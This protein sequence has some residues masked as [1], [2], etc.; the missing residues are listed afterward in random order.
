MKK[1]MHIAIG[2]ALLF[3]AAAAAAEELELSANK[4][5]WLDELDVKLS[6]C[7]WQTTLKGK[8]VAGNPLRLRGKT[9]ARGIGTHTPGIFRIDLD[10]HGVR[11][12]ATVGVDDE[13]GNGGTVEFRVSGDGKVLWSSGVLRGGKEIKTCDVAL[14]GVKTL[15]LVVDPT[16]DGYGNDHSDWVDAKIEYVGA[17]PPA[18]KKTANPFNHRWPPAD[19]VFNKA[20]LP[21]P[22]DRDEADAV[23]RRVAALVDHLKNTL[24]CSNLDA[25]EARLAELKAAA[26]KTELSDA[27]GRTKLLEQAC[28]LRREV[29][30]SNP[31]LDFDQILFIKRHFCPDAE[32]TGNHMCDQMF[33]FNA[34]RGGG[35]FV[36]E[37]PFSDKPTVRN[38]LEKSVCENAR[39][40]GKQLTSDGG[41]LAPELRFDAREILFAWT[42]IA[43]K[44]ADRKRYRTWDEHNTWK[45]FRV[46]VDGSALTQLTDGPWDDF[47]PCYLPNGRIVFIS[48]R[49]G[50]Y[51]RCHGRPVPSFTLHS[52]NRD[53]SDIVCLSP[54]ETNE[55]QP[56]IDHNGMIIYTRWDYVDRGFSQAH[57]PWTT[58]PDGRDPR[59]IHGNYATNMSSRP[60]FEISIRAVPN[61]R[62]YMATAACHHGQAYGS[63]LLIDPSVPDDDKMGPVKR[64]TPDQLFPEAEIGTH[65]DPACYAAPYPLSEYFFLCVYDAESRSNAG[66]RN[67]YGIYLVDAFGNKELLYRDPEISCL[68]PIPLKAQPVP[69]VIPNQTA[70]GQPLAEGATAAPPDPKSVPDFGLVGLI[71]VYDSLYAM[72]KDAKITN[73]RVMQL[74]PKTT[75]YAN[76]PQIGFGDQKSARM[77]LGTVPV[78]EDG[79]AYFKLPVGRPVYFQALDADGLAVQSMRSATYIHPGEKL[80]CRGCHEPRV[81]TSSTAQKQPKAFQ[82]PPSEIVPDV[83]GS[84]PFSYPI[85][86]QPVLDK[87]CVGCHEKSRAEG[88]KSPDLSRGVNNKKNWYTSYVS[89][90]SY[91]F[92]WDNAVFDGVPRTTPGKFGAHASKLYQMLAKGHH[93]LK[94]SPE[95]MHRLTL[96]LDSNSDFYG[97]YENLTEQLE[98]KVVWTKLE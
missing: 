36:L 84:R 50:G 49:R 55:W 12:E 29:A 79:S 57:H 38:V 10:K 34:I 31:L 4:V 60:Q 62:K 40:Q 52:M 53:G 26:G 69:P 8:S 88:K 90:R 51:G 94:L 15:D 70:V 24:G 91:A 1:T 56:S 71:N 16:P 47:D 83:A 39:F 66:T 20:A 61:S 17:K 7:G 98:G 72:P 27:D 76:N 65:G 80:T 78:E 59:P 2:T 6:S 21:D 68:D 25:K 48:E 77:V 81:R 11:F 89:L 67:N 28:A 35:L 75:P 63:I 45:I 41:F 95:E 54:H 97:S 18:A 73:L 64:M 22:A 3:V 30:F 37:K 42:E 9:Y 87:N 46:N 82:R 23:L 13:V 14:A 43:E 33:G 96:W 58:T 93:D 32:T 5:I 19:Q 74:L 92:F 44:E 85:L 86:V